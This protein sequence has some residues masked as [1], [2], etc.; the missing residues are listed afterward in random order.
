MVS[1]QATQPVQSAHPNQA[2]ATRIAEIRRQAVVDHLRGE[3]A[4]AQAIA[5]SERRDVRAKKESGEPGAQA[6]RRAEN[7]AA[8]QQYLGATLRA[9]GD[10]R[11]FKAVS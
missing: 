8:I 4:R 7:A 5:A 10:N 1:P 6:Q 11:D 3:L 2:E 9:F